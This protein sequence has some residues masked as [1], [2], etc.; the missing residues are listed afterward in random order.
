MKGEKEWPRKAMNRQEKLCLALMLMIWIGGSCVVDVIMP[1]AS[2]EEP[3]A[4]Q[5]MDKP[6]VWI[7]I[8]EDIPAN[9]AMELWSIEAERPDTEP[10][11]SYIPLDKPLVDALISS[12]EEWGVPLELA[13]GVIEVESNFDPKVVNPVS[14]CYGLMQLSPRYFPGGLTPVE[15][16]QAGVAYLGELLER[17]GDDQGTALAAYNAGYDTGNRAYANAVL[18]ATEKWGAALR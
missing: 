5:A 1:P 12:C 13:L 14:G 18:A 7:H 11:Y 6:V 9:S 15:N 17:Y 10:D 3:A 16:I 2:A 8:T 4:V